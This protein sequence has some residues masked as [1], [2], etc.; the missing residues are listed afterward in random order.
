M[1][2]R[3]LKASDRK[4]NAFFSIVV[5]I[6]LAV[7]SFNI[8]LDGNLT[9]S[10]YAISVVALVFV[11]PVLLKDRTALPPFEILVYL[12]IPFTIQG[13][14]LG[15]IASHTLNYLS[16]AGIA[17]LLVSELDTFTSFKTTPGF[18]VILVSMA[19]VAI[20][21][22]WAVGRWLSNIYLGTQIKITE[23]L[24]MWEF[25]AAL[26]A[27]ILAGKIFGFYFRRKDRRLA[28]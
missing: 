3:L 5:S 26:L 16:A 23:Y 8:F 15:F 19:T 10:M 18:A 17:L 4:R 13:L 12:A 11:P 27:G 2:Q 20:A 28:I 22:F 24:L 21:G 9:W 7:N 6:Y 25:A 14:E 1:R